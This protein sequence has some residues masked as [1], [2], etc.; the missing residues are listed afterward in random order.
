[1]T[2]DDTT[3]KVIESVLDDVFKMEQLL[4][5]IDRSRILRTIEALEA[6]D[7]KALQEGVE[8]LHHTELDVRM[9]RLRIQA[10]TGI[11]PPSLVSDPDRTPAEP[12]QVRRRSSAS[13]AI[14][15]PKPDKP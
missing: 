12:I 3:K 11:Q 1:M 9:A 4:S 7:L 8:L 10:I 13:I 15:R 14:P 6:L 2:L 5:R